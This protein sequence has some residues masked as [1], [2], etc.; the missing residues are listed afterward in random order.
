M[1]T[2]GI[3]LVIALAVSGMVSGCSPIPPRPVKA[4]AKSHYSDDL[5]VIAA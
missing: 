4:A 2:N 1:K 5:I 3:F